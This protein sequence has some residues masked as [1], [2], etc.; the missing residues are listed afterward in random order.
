MD[1]SQY[2]RTELAG[3]ARDE[4][5]AAAA[6]WSNGDDAGNRSHG[7][8]AGEIRQAMRDGNYRRDGQAA[9]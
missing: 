7:A 2:S 4:V 8:K 6:A 5:D 3:M 9:S 1:Y